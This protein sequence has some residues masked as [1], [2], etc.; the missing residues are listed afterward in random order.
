QAV[1]GKDDRALASLQ[2]LSMDDVSMVASER[3]LDP[4]SFAFAIDSVG[5]AALAQQPLTLEMLMRVFGTSG[6]LPA[7]RGELFEAGVKELAS[8]RARRVEE[9]TAID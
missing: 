2:A 3:G 4:V 6:R 9:G 8:E 1:Y 5:A 7:K